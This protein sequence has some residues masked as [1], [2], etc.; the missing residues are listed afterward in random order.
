[1][2]RQARIDVPGQVYHVMARGIERGSIFCDEA[3]YADFFKR[4][5]IWFKKSGSKCLSWCLMPNHFHFLILRGERPL[6]ETMH[7]T[8]TGYAV[9]FNLRHGR[10]GHLFQNRYK[11][12][13]C[14]LEEYFLELVPY[15]HLNPLRAG[16]VKDLSE[17]EG[18]RWCGHGAAMGSSPAEILDRN[19]LLAHYGACENEGVEKYWQIISEKAERILQQK[20]GDTMPGGDNSVD[21]AFPLLGAGKKEFPDQRILGDSIFVESVLHSAGEAMKKGRKSPSQVLEEVE[22]FTGVSRVDIFRRTHEPAPAR[23]RAVYC[24]LCKEEAGCSGVEL[25]RALRISDSAVSRLAAKGRIIFESVRDS[26]IV[27]NV[28]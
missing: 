1:M 6:S 22:I 24:Y 8:M 20:F 10:V 4:V 11:A 13:I 19:T 26:Q 9:G 3:D 7:H 27:N 5:S 28:P 2:P 17:L 12:I 23:A 15:I 21:G 14:G 18:Y 16:M 25:R